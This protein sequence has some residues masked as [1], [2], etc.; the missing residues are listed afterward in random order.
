MYQHM[1]GGRIN[2]LK[3]IETQEVEEEAEE[4]GEAEAEEED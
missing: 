1:Y 2:I 4:A 3:Q